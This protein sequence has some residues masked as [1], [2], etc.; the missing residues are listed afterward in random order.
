MQSAPDYALYARIYEVVEQIPSG[1]VS[2]YGDV[3]VIVGGGCD[4]RTVGFALNELPKER[5]ATVP[6]QRVINREGGI[7]TR[8][9]LQRQML[10]DEGVAFDERER[11]IL[12]RFRWHGPSAEWAEVHRFNT[13]PP[14]EEG[15]QLSMFS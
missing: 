10:E 2:T 7:S 8:G 13:L 11:V 4:G 6:W 14:R 3:A 5:M 9:L 1:V 15:E 12:A